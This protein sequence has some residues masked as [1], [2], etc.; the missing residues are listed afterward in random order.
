MLAAGSFRNGLMSRTEV[1]VPATV[2]AVLLNLLAAGLFGLVAALI[3]ALGVA[4]QRGL[5]LAEDAE[6]LLLLARLRGQA[7]LLLAAAAVLALAA[8]WALLR[9]HTALLG[10]RSGIRSAEGKAVAAG[11]LGLVL[12]ALHA[13][14]ATG[15]PDGLAFGLALAVLGLLA[16]AVMA[17]AGTPDPAAR[18][19]EA[20]LREG[21]SLASL[22]PGWRGPGPASGGLARPRRPPR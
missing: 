16:F 4:L 14:A 22:R 10:R 3:A 17:G 20:P 21:L 15:S 19:P 5:P 1:P 12:A 6:T 11:L 18:R 13:F 2:A 7:L 9:A 8:G